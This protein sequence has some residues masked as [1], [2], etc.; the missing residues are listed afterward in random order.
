[1]GHIT[2]GQTERRTQPFP[3]CN[4]KKE[5]MHHTTVAYTASQTRT[6]LLTSPRVLLIS[7]FLS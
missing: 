3:F 2:N 5:R 7:F 6:G 1:M 4:E